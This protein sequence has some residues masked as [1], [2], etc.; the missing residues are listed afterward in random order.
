MG[1]VEDLLYDQPKQAGPQQI[2]NEFREFVLRYFM[3][4]SAFDDPEAYAQPGPPP[5]RRFPRD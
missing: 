4:I 1:I 3:R 2:R 5:L